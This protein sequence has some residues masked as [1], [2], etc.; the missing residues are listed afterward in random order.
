MAANVSCKLPEVL[1]EHDAFERLCVHH[2]MAITLPRQGPGPGFFLA[3]HAAC[4]SG[5]SAIK[6]NPN[7]SPTLPSLHRRMRRVSRGVPALRHRLLDREGRSDIE[8]LY[9]AGSRLR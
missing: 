7:A 2:N 1:R 3:V 4:H 5:T 9:S 6:E 8:H